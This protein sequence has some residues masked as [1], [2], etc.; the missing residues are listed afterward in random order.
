MQLPGFERGRTIV[1]RRP[2]GLLGSGRFTVYVDN[3]LVFG[4]SE[5]DVRDKIRRAQRC[6]DGAGLVT[7]E[8]ELA[9]TNT[10]ALGWSFDGAAGELRPT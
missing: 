5:K 7:H 1:D 4:G 6:L 8:V 9:A 2:T 3:L 10:E